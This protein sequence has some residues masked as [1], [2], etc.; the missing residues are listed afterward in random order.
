MEEEI[1]RDGNWIV[2][3]EIGVVDEDINLDWQVQE[4]S[5]EITEQLVWQE[6]DLEKLLQDF[7]TENSRCED[8]DVLQDIGLCDLVQWVND[9][10]V[11]TFGTVS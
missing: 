9:F 10:D 4:E 11:T 8:E 5:Q 7:F 1:K 6:E 3:S 2:L